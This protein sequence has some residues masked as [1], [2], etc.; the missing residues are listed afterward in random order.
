MRYTG[1]VRQPERIFAACAP[2]LEPVLARELQELGLEVGAVPGGAEAEGADALALAC[3]GSRVA[4][5]VA[6]RLYRGPESGLDAAFARERRRFGTAARIALRRQAGEATLS[7]DA[8]GAPL[9]KRG[10]RARV[11]A[12]PLRESLAAGMLLWA[13]Y[14]GTTPFLDPMCGSGTLAIE[15]AEIAA[16]RA[17]GRTRRFAFEGWPG[18]DPARTAAVRA[19]LAAAERPPPSP[20]HASDRNAGALRLALCNAAAAG[21]TGAIR[22]ERRDAAAVVPPAGSGLLLVNPPYGLRLPEDVERS[23]QALGSLLDRLPGWTAVVLSAGSAA[24]RLLARRPAASIRVRNA[25]LPC[26]LLRFAC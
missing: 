8:V 25:A 21:F 7:L 19:R 15:A 3:V 24:E 5:A 14:D 10:W 20:I 2:G 26:L 23:W 9:Y 18:H 1:L 13:G 16:R 12:A 22:F 6:L 4:D 17:P 11:G